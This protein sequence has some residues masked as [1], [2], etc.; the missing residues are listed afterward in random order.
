MGWAG[1]C[2]LSDFGEHARAQGRPPAIEIKSHLWDIVGHWSRGGSGMPLNC[3]RGDGLTIAE[4][5]EIEP[6][7][8]A[9]EAVCGYYH[10]LSAL[11][12]MAA[13]VAVKIVEVARAGERNPERLRELALQALKKSVLS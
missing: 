11:D 8:S 9:H 7:V 12:P 2:G 6:L 10:I 5:E 13:I 1:R 3:E 4:L